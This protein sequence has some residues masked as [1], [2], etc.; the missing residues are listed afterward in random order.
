MRQ[1]LR[2]IAIRVLRILPLTLVRTAFNLTAS[3]QPDEYKLVQGVVTMWGSIANLKRNSFVPRSIIDIGAYV[4]EWTQGVRT[5]YP[6]SRCLMVE[7]NP[8]K[9]QALEAVRTTLRG[10]V[11]VHIA[12]LGAEP[13]ESMPFYVVG[14]GSSVL[15]EH[16]SVART[17]ISLPMCTLDEVAAEAQ[18]EPPIF[19]KLDVQGYELEVLRGGLGVLRDTEVVLLEVSLMEYN[20]DAPLFAEVVAFMNSK[21]FVPYDICGQ[22]RRQT[23]RALFQVDVIFVRNDSDLRTRKRWWNSEHDVAAY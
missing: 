17:R 1:F 7:A 20:Q 5:I 21:G 13:R 16:T 6:E 18:V 15:S 8:D 23:D 14:T 9:R 12:L 2:R 19:L 11:S 10:G 3:V 4:G 22:H